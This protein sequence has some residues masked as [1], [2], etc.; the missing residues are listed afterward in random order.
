MLGDA[1]GFT[2][3]DVGL[4]DV[5]QQRR[6]PVVHVTHDGDDRGTGDLLLRTLLALIGLG[7]G[8]V[9]VFPDSLEP[10]R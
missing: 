6:L 8:R 1:A 2:G 5:I 3:D 9:L 4:P 7:F 10:E